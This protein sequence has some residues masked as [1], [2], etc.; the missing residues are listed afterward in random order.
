MS[1]TVIYRLLLMFFL[2]IGGISSVVAQTITL[3]NSACPSA[4]VT[5]GAG[6]IAINTSGC[7]STGT[8]PQIT[9][10]PLPA[11][12]VG[13]AYT[14]LFQASG[15][16]ASS[17]SV[18][19]GILPAG[20]SLNPT[21]GILSGI[22]TVTG[23]F[24][25]TVQAANGI[26]PNATQSVTLQIDP[27]TGPPIINS[28]ALPA[29]AV[30]VAYSHTFTASGAQ[31]VNWTA[32]G[33]P[34]WA[35]VSAAGVLTGTPPVGAAASTP[36]TI[37]ATN[38]VSS[39]NQAL[40]LA[41][42]APVAPTITSAAPVATGSVGAAYNFTFGATGTGPIT[43]SVATGSV[44]TGLNLNATTGLLSGT[45]T[46]AGVFTF[47]VRATNAVGPA[48]SGTFTV[49]IGQ[50]SAGGTSIDGTSIPS[51]SKVAKILT[52]IHA[53]LNGAGTNVNAWAV[54][55]TRCSNTQPAITTAWHHNIDF[56]DHGGKQNLD[57]FDMA[58][59][60]ALT[61]QF[62]AGTTGVGS[63]TVGDSTQ[64]P[65]VATFISLS[66]SPCDFDVTKLVPGPT[67]SFC[68]S[69]QPLENSLAYEVTSGPV[70]FVLNCKLIP[71][72]TYYLN[73][74]FQDGVTPGANTTDSCAP[75]GGARCGGWIQIRR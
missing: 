64:V 36:F 63:I 9:S 69:S 14:H 37:T 62:V 43:W 53:G 18:S 75:R 10:G 32:T 30:G 8:A 72:N 17:W 67:R 41:V 45:P 60:E 44:P 74:R 1:P 3:N 23:S 40:T 38:A 25:F 33:L 51:P 48:T 50:P 35:S 20:L 11:V 31:P 6:T 12:T 46:A 29:A 34:A 59:N 47:A 22:S 65:L 73:L 13:V 4:T 56:A 54:S 39:A 70:S 42:T 68:Y 19:T 49:T 15:S 61:Y 2:A 52:P 5:F 55:P 27:A 26:S 7:T 24:T 58:P 16:P 57:Y 21:S 66:S 28:A 71:G